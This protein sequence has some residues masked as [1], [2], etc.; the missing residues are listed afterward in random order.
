MVNAISALISGKSSGA[1]LFIY[2]FIV[3]VKNIGDPD[4]PADLGLQ[5]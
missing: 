3:W 2:R 5:C 1:T 4:Q